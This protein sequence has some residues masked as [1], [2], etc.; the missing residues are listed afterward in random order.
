MK[1]NGYY[2]TI[3]KLVFTQ[4]L[5][6]WTEYN[7]RSNSKVEYWPSQLGLKNT[8]TA[9]LQRG[10]TQPPHNECPGYD[11]KQFDGEAPVML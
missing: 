1:E 10:K 5:P 11:T 6:P 2:I 8:L 7:T 9:S 4:S 3:L